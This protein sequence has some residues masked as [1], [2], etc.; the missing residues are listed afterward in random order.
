MEDEE[1]AVVETVED[2]YEELG[3]PRIQPPPQQVSYGTLLAYTY[4]CLLK[5]KQIKKKQHLLVV[6]AFFSFLRI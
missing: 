1:E 4:V 5:L 6:Q 2:R 3:G